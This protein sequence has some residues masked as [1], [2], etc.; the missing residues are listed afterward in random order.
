M[1]PHPTSLQCTSPSTAR[2]R[3]L[4]SP[5]WPPT[6]S[7]AATLRATTFSQARP[8]TPVVRHA[9]GLRSA[10][11]SPR[12]RF[13]DPPAD[14]RPHVHRQLKATFTDPRCE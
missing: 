2:A 4:C 8:P 3:F 5:A 12:R 1:S 6:R 11:C 9:P 7:P 13:S 14:P 10:P